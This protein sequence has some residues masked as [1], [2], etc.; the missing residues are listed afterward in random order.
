MPLARDESGTWTGRITA[1]D[2]LEISQSPPEFIDGVLD[3]LN[4]FDLLFRRAR[5]RCELEFLFSLFR[6]RGVRDPG[7]DP[8]E[9]TVEA[10]PA[11]EKLHRD[12]Q[13]SVAS[14]HLELWIYGHVMEAAEP[15]EML[16]NLLHV[17]NGGCYSWSTN[18]PAKRNGQAQTPG[19]K[20][21]GIQR[22]AKETGHSSA[23]AG[24]DEIWDR[25]LR[26][27]I[28]HSNY[29]FCGSE[30]RILSPPRV[31]S[32]KEVLKLVNRALG[33]LCAVMVLDAYHKRSYAEPR[34]IPTSPHFRGDPS[35]RWIVIVREGYGAVGVKDAWS[36]DDLRAG[37]IPLRVGRFSEAEKRLLDRDHSVALL[38]V[39]SKGS[40]G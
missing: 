13:E 8:F 4:A 35:L 18:F 37:R 21:R 36:P 26:N 14:G 33:Y 23:V 9:T 15:Y 27:A 6:V 38:P 39:P 2:G 32:S 11:I 16:Y 28:F 30:L 3:F 10:I 20:I 7:W 31:Y 24:L 19:E 40:D 22:L 29:A 12:N 25:N 5:E 17:A 1:E 34:V